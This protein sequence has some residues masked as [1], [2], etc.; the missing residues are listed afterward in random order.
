MKFPKLPRPFRSRSE[1]AV[2][3]R[4]GGASAKDHKLILH[5]GSQ[6]T[7]TTAIQF[8]LSENR[9]HLASVGVFYPRID[10]FFPVDPR[11][12]RARAHFAFANAV[13]DFTPRDRK[14][15]SR[16]VEA[17]H[18]Q[19]AVHDRTIL[20]AESLYRLIARSD[21]GAGRQPM[22]DRRMR[23]LERLATVTAGF[24][25]E[26]LLYLRRIDRYAASIYAES[27]VKTDK[28]W[29]FREFLEAKDQHFGYRGK[30]DR[31]KAHFP[32]RVRNFESAAEAGLLQSFCADAGI[33]GA[34]PETV[35][36]RRPSVPHTAVL[37]LQQAKLDS[38]GMGVIERDRRWHFALRAENADVFEAETPTSFWK[39]RATRDAFIE[40]HQAGVTEIAFPE[41]DPTLAPE[42]TWTA[43]RHAD[44][45][46][47]FRAWQAANRA[48]LR[49][50]ER[51]RVPPFVLDA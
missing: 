14:R 4:P 24:D 46:Q 15:L 1:S 7:G 5:A 49:R 40:R 17:I 28:T 11:L 26:I 21:P 29:S 22:L 43:A 8:A 33:P 45:E 36:R 2:F 18:A 30:I 10:A 41:P 13:A 47:R 31:F 34:L 9:D 51:D 42:A 38:P 6:K 3:A 25:T 48:M 19:A 44:A 27:I 12:S 39:D 16:F 50:R 37:W 35:E 32:V 20:S 23:F